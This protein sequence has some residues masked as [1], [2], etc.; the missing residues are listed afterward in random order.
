[1][2]DSEKIEIKTA[3]N[4]YTDLLYNQLVAA[5]E[6]AEVELPGDIDDNQRHMMITNLIKSTF[7]N[8]QAVIKKGFDEV[9]EKLKDKDFI[10]KLREDVNGR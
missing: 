6:A 9:N 7:E 10:N 5:I 4:S 1:M 8:Q 3:L 2:T